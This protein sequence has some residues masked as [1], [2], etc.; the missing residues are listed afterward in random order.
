MGKLVD[1]I[2]KLQNYEEFADLNWSGGFEDY[3]NIVRENPSVTR[4][5]FQRVYD[6]VLSY[7][8]ET[9]LDNKKKLIHYNFFDDPMGDGRDS[10]FGLDIPPMRLV[11]VLKSAALG[12]ELKTRHLAPRTCGSSKSTIARLLK[13]GLEQYSRT[14]EGALYTYE[15][16][17]PDSLCISLAVYFDAR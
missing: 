17:L 12:T 8:S 14:A 13:K 2:A 7:G 11:N 6:M 15:W 1:Q 4:T 5:S 9:Y 10:I 16:H 3:L